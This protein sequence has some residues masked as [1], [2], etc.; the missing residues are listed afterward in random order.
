M[1]AAVRQLL[2]AAVVADDARAAGRAAE[3]LATARGRGPNLGDAHGLLAP[4]PVVA[5]P[6]APPAAWRVWHA[7][8][9]GA[10]PTAL[11]FLRTGM[12]ALPGPLAEAVPAVLLYLLVR[13]SVVAEG[14]QGTLRD[15]LAL[16]TAEPPGQVRRR[17]HAA[18][19]RWDNLTCRGVGPRV[20]R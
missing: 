7:L 2:H 14:P 18:P 10:T 1:V 16:L 12:P 3:R 13:L 5:D 4:L 17:T 11:Q 20:W 6:L 8:G 15:A 19:Y 9:L